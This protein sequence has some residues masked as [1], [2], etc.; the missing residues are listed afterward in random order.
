MLISC[1]A[2]TCINKF[3]GSSKLCEHDEQSSVTPFGGFE[4][5]VTNEEEDDEVFEFAPREERREGGPHL[6]VK[7]SLQ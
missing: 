4:V 1:A 7:R 6:H 3:H 5:E 2:C